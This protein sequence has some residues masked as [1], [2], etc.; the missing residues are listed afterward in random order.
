MAEK[1]KLTEAD[2]T[3]DIEIPEV[4]ETKYDDNVNISPEGSS[5]EA[6]V[7]HET[8]ALESKKMGAAGEITASTL[9]HLLNIPNKNEFKILEKKI[10]LVSSRLNSLSAK[11]DTIVSDISSGSLMSALTR[12][13]EQLLAMQQ[14]VDSKK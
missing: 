4:K 13:D 10:D 3:A 2:K 6:N 5:H 14:K 9:L 7:A 11:I 12:I 1:D 8:S